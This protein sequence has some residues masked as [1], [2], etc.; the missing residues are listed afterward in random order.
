MTATDRGGERLAPAMPPAATSPAGVFNAH[1]NMVIVGAYTSV[2][3]GLLIELAPQGRM[4]RRWLR[5]VGD[6]TV[7]A[8]TDEHPAP[9]Y[10]NRRG[11]TD[12]QQTD[13]GDDMYEREREDRE[14]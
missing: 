4:S 13:I 2:N 11:I 8:D 7:R 3:G 9:T 1:A 12:Q 10:R 5:V 14:P 6:F